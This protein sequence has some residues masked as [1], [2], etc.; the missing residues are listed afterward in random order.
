MIGRQSIVRIIVPS[1]SKSISP[2]RKKCFGIGLSTFV[3]LRVSNFIRQSIA[4]LKCAY[5]TNALV[6]RIARCNVSVV[7]VGRRAATT[8]Q[9]FQGGEA[10]RDCH[11]DDGGGGPERSATIAGARASPPLTEPQLLRA[12]QHEPARRRHA[13]YIRLPPAVANDRRLRH[14]NARSLPHRQCRRFV[15][16]FIIPSELCQVREKDMSFWKRWGLLLFLV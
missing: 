14:R 7:S 16:H 12:E 9:A 13:V 10:A 6:R 11:D 8:P 3:T 15:S 5:N 4:R 1:L 2:D